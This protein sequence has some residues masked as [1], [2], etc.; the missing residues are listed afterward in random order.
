M[1]SN[2]SAVCQGVTVIQKSEKVTH[3]WEER[4]T[5][6]TCF[7]SFPAESET[8]VMIFLLFHRYV[9]LFLSDL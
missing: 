9:L 8:A 2:A 5:P 3:H 4:N 7:L 1:N 6:M